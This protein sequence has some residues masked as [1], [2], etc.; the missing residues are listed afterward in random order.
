MVSKK[1]KKLL[2]SVSSSYVQIPRPIQR[3]KRI[4][5]IPI[6]TAST[7][8]TVT[9]IRLPRNRSENPPK[10]PSDGRKNTTIDKQKASPGADRDT[11]TRKA[12]PQALE[13]APIPALHKRRRHWLQVGPGGLLHQAVLYRDLTG[14]GRRRRRRSEVLQAGVGHVPDGDQLQLAVGEG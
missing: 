11:L 2:R 13:E 6:N 3:S 10:R 7:P 5:G 4:L 1:K 8:T 9:N 14:R 12:Q